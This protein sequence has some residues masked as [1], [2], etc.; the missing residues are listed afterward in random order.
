MTVPAFPS[1]RI[2]LPSKRAPIW[3]SLKQ[4]GIGGGETRIPLWSYPQWQYE[5]Q[6][7]VLRSAAAYAEFQSLVGLYNSVMASAGGAF[8]FTDPSDGAVAAQPFGVGD[9]A[10]T[11]FQLVR[12]LGGFTEPVF[13]P[14]GV[15]ISAQTTGAPAVVSS[16]TYSIGPT[17]AIT[18]TTPPAAATALSWTGTFNWLCRFDDDRLDLQ[19]DYSA[20]WSTS[21]LK[22][23]T[24]KL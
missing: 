13:S 5:L 1:L 22:F 18:F 7:E 17:G 11:V 14:T 2:L 23:T 12:A 9:G 21:G 15:T 8:S 10:T 4:K 6:I 24:V 19:Q 3:S 20:I 16:S